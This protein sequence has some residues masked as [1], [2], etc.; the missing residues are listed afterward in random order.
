MYF[1]DSATHTYTDDAGI[2][3]PGVTSCLPKNDFAKDK[4]AAE[5]GTAVHRMIE[6]YAQDDLDEDSIIP[7]EDQLDLRPY[8]D[9]Y[10]S[11]RAQHKD[12]VGICDIKTGAPMPITVLQLAGYVKL[13]LEGE[14]EDC[15]KPPYLG[16]EVKLFH[17]IYKYAGTIDIIEVEDTKRFPVHE[18]QLR[19]DGTYRL[20]HDY[21]KDL[22]MNEGY[23][24]S[25]MVAH[26]WQQKHMKGA[27]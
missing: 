18:L 27:Y 9:A 10:K 15:L 12:A 24:M 20:S 2:V 11:F 19:P 6:L 1:F 23:F 8:L 26:R 3:Y 7:A 13:Y 22:R 5:R 16:Y 25:F 21:W 14:T 17:P 4:Q